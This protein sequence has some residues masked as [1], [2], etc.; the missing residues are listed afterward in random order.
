MKDSK[1]YTQKI[2]KLYKSLKK[3]SKI[4]TRSFDDPVDAIVYAIVSENMDWAETKTMI[5]K[6]D[7]HFIDINDLR[8]SREEEIMDVLGETDANTLKTASTMRQVLEAILAK[9]NIVSL[10][11]LKE[12]GKRQAKKELE[13]IDGLSSFAA[14][15][16]FLTSLGGH[17]VPLTD[18]MIE[19]LKDNDLVHPKSKNSDIE[20]FLERQITAANAYEFYRLLKTESQKAAKVK[21]K[22]AA[23]KNAKKKAVEKAAKKTA[24]KKAVKKT[25]KKAVKKTAKKTAVKK[26]AKKTTKKKTKTKKKK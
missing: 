7:R 21:R 17:A 9:H 1:K 10:N 6:M 13:E 3:D 23:K 16:C 22:A 20:G 15:Y 24:K 5:K 14:N 12:I 18:D 4:G 8:V 19:Y 2:S 26:T 25:A 11:H